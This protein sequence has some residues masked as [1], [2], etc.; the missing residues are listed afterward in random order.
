M[1]AMARP[2]AF[3]PALP[4]A[5]T[6][7]LGCIALT[8]LLQIELAFHK[9]LNWDEFF[10]YS[11]ISAAARG[12][13]VTLLQAPF[14][15]LFGWVPSLA[16][17]SGLGQIDAVVLIRL[18]LLPFELTA[19]YAIYRCARRL[20]PRDNA[21]LAALAY[22]TAGFV[23]QHGFALRADAIAA[24]LLSLALWIALSAEM[25]LLKVVVSL[26]LIALATISTMKSVL[27]APVFIAVLILRSDMTRRLQ[28]PAVLF[29]IIAV[30]LALAAAL[31]FAL[32]GTHALAAAE[33]MFGGG[34]LPRGDYLAKQA[35]I[36]PFFTV[37]LIVGVV[38]SRK[39]GRPWWFTAGMLAPLGSTV[40]YF[41]AFPYFYVFALPPA[42]LAM[43]PGIDWVR[44]RYGVVSV[45]VLLAANALALSVV[46]DRGVMD[47]QRRALAG[48][49]AVFPEPVSYIDDAGL[50]AAYPRA[51]PHYASGWAL[52][53]YRDRGEASYAAA[54]GGG[55]PVPLL[56]RMGPALEKVAPRPNDQEA[57]LGRD[58]DTLRETYIRYWGPLYIPGEIV[59]AGTFR[60]ARIEVPGTY[61]VENAPLT[62]GDRTIPVG[63]TIS[64]DRSEV[65]LG[66]PE[67]RAVLRWADA[68]PRPT[69][70]WPEGPFYTNY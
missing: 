27:W 4:S 18:L 40:F 7:V 28:S 50:L 60:N 19:A 46:E 10:H 43:L 31:P 9:S 41:N 20:G 6:I 33:R 3:L 26:A 61:I 24:A 44:Q 25:R 59:A 5:R 39:A 48:I 42:V 70:A 68:G 13:S 37:M 47:T 65:R 11:L 45:A 62:I 21:I 29:G 51:V 1:V 15:V 69:A 63:G 14:V 32:G 34:L 8:V 36:A 58:A 55:A 54:I 30:A 52:E 64:L 2:A 53:G 12:D 49:E 67:G 35:L 23:F 66:A 56:L 38:R 17:G 16:A 57:L 22:L